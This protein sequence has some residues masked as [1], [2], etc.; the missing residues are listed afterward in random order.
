MHLL[1]RI[2]IS[3]F[4][5]TQL[6][7]CHLLVWKW[8]RRNICLLCTYISTL[9]QAGCKLNLPRISQKSGPV[10]IYILYIYKKNR[11]CQNIQNHSTTVGPRLFDLGY[12]E[13]L[14]I[15]NSKLF[16]LDFSFLQSI[17]Y[18]EHPLF[19]TVIH[20]PWEFEIPE[21]NC[22]RSI[23]QFSAAFAPVSKQVF[24]K[25]IQIWKKVA[26]LHLHF[27]INKSLFFIWKALYADSFW[28]RGARYLGNGLYYSW[29]INYLPLIRS[30]YLR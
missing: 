8:R 22:I 15:S 1:I 5:I 17:G 14:V 10:A 25:T 16:S 21:F 6:D 12:F 27:H 19:R 3:F 4:Y 28:N 18:L 20:F 24:A 30:D 11:W 23:G 9:L 13:F 29:P 2:P 7:S 26:H